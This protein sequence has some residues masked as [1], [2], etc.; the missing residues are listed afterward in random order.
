MYEGNA[1]PR[2]VG[3]AVGVGGLVGAAVL[4]GCETIS[5]D[6]RDLAKGLMPPTPREAAEQML[7]PHEPDERRE[8]T[9]LI[10]NS[11]FGGVDVY[12][13][14]YRDRVMHEADPL[15]KA[16]SIRALARHGMPE[17]APLIAEH[18]EH[19][20]VQVRWEAAKGLQ[21]LHNPEVVPDL[22]AALRNV[23]GNSDVR[24]AAADALGQYAEDRVF[25]GLLAALDG[26]DLA[27][28]RAAGKSLWTLTGQEMGLDPRA[29][30]SWYNAVEG[31]PFAGRQEYLFPT[32]HRE[33]TWL[34][35]LAFW[36]S[37]VEEQPA[38][39]AG[40]RPGTQRRTYENSELESFGEE[41]G[42]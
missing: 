27:L 34:E 38:P 31:D 13:R 26:R 4:C 12:I 22:L 28:N 6:L 29:W 17:D 11:P 16:V 37:R 42:G 36:T 5:Q 35:R 19:E 33:D 1:N 40:L 10:A 21:R 25:Q 14:A 30:L 39:P 23:N 18:L 15:V 20:N 32:Y 2:R 8:G 9:L 41:A 3:A 7:N 24:A